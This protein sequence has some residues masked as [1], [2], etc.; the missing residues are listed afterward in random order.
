V[1]NFCT[2]IL[3]S[4]F[5]C[6]CRREFDKSKKNGKVPA[7]DHFA[8]ESSKLLGASQSREALLICNALGVSTVASL[9]LV[10]HENGQVQDIEQFL[11]TQECP[12]DP[13]SHTPGLSVL[14]P[15]SCEQLLQYIMQWLREPRHHYST[16][17]MRTVQM[18]GKEMGNPATAGFL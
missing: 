16:R 15:P 10:Q 1:F 8:H 6:T 18:Q 4:S 13:F 5:R 9:R 11:N 14:K 17:R 7:H 2:A 12:L 3:S